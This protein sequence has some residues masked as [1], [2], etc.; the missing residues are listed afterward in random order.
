[1]KGWWHCHEW[2]ECP[3]L[4]M[5]SQDRAGPTMSG[6][7]HTL[8]VVWMALIVFGTTYLFAFILHQG[9]GALSAGPAARSFK[10]LSPG[11]LPPLGIVFGLFVAFTAAQVGATATTPMRQSTGR[12]AHCGQS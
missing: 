4:R 9:V 10:A 6:W 7:L 3:I 2:D 5:D 11:M 12:R 8:P 1:M